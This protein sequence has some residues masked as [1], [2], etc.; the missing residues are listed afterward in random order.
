M[1]DQ[2]QSPFADA[3]VPTPSATSGDQGIGG[4]LDAGS[5]ESG[6]RQAPWGNAPVPA[7]SNMEESGPFGNPSRFSSLDGGTHEGETLQ[8]DI[9][10]PPMHTIDKK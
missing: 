6:L 1:S 9:T 3:V 10:Q 5:G 2:H 4:G 8:G 7:P